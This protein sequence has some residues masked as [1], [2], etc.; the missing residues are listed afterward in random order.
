MT[1][2]PT[3]LVC[4]ESYTRV[5]NHAYWPKVGGPAAFCVV[6]WH[7]GPGA[8]APELHH[9]TCTLTPEEEDLYPKT[10]DLA[11]ELDRLT[12]KEGKS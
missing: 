7:Q 8:T 1:E 11:A 9:N 4:G 3:C 10:V 5:T 12:K 2:T 6:F